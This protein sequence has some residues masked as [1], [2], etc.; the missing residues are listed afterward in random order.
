MKVFVTGVGG[1]LGFDVMN[2]LISRGHEAV[3]SDIHS[4]YQGGAQA[5]PWPYLSL[6]I[7]DKAKVAETICQ[8]Q[9]DAV[10]HCAAWTAVD[11]AEEE[12]NKAKVQAINAVSYTHLRAQRPY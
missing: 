4:E 7:T 10:I 5:A 2:E 12:E 8:L 9:P 3:G 1:Q 6:D 11:L